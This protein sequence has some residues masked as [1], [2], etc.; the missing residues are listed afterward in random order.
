M[1]KQEMGKEKEQKGEGGSKG[2]G[3]RRKEEGRE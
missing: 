1:E 2:K 3:E